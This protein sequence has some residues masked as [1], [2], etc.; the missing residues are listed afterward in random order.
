M[1]CKKSQHPFKTMPFKFPWVHPETQAI[2]SEQSKAISDKSQCR[3]PDPVLNQD[4]V[5]CIFLFFISFLG[6]ICIYVDF[7]LAHK[8]TGEASCTRGQN[9][10]G[11]E[12]A[13]RPSTLCLKVSLPS[14]FLTASVN[15]SKSHSCTWKWVSDTEQDVRVFLLTPSVVLE[16]FKLKYQIHLVCEFGHK[17]AHPVWK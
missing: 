13:Q 15:S 2:V 8:V 12:C 5:T 7:K 1:N 6:H 3:Y 16:P 11:K 4:P 14:M 9:I 17:S 10:S